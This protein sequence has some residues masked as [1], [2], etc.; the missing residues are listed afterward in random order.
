MT[1]TH[2]LE[3]EDLRRL[4]AKLRPLE[5]PCPSKLLAKLDLARL[6]DAHLAA[7]CEGLGLPPGS[8]K[9]LVAQCGQVHQLGDN[10]PPIQLG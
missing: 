4:G 3:P 5:W 7:L 2:Q 8:T 9:Q 10:R 1:E 6:P